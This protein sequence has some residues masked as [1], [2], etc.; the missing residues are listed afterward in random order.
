M[1]KAIFNWSGGKDS[2]FCLYKV[3]TE[4]RYKVEY[5][6]TSVSKDHHR[7]SMHGIREEL[8]DAQAQS[9]GISVKKVWLTETADHKQY[10][11]QMEATLK[12]FK[13]TGI[14]N[15]LFGDI[16]L[17]DIRQYRENQLN[18][19]G[20]KALFPLWK[21][22][23]R[24]LAIDFIEAGFK[25]IVVCVDE[26]FLDRSFA[27]REYDK[28]FLEDLPENVDLCGENGEFHTFVFG[29][30]IFKQEINIIKG[31]VVYRKYSSYTDPLLNTGFYY[32]DLIPGN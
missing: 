21:Y 8:L 10:E 2:A 22:N 18:K 4:N 15:S 19:L 11:N 17:K 24:K 3:L 28:S 12:E 32:C 1:E 29:G 20:F 16:F 13:D 27:G 7:I 30:P 26:K 31:E 5:L 6:L 23:T 9:I 14:M 25:S